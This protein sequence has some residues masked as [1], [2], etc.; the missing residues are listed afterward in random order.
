LVCLYFF[1]CSLEFLSTSF[2]LLS[3]RHAGQII[4]VL[5]FCKF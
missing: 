2:R 3:G 5:I 4:S 1:I